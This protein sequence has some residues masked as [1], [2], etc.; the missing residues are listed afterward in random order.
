MSLARPP[1]TNHAGESMVG[2]CPLSNSC[3][4]QLALFKIR[5]VVAAAAAD[6]LPNCLPA[7]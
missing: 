1:V 2:S 6:I 3:A 7:G 5:L 4:W